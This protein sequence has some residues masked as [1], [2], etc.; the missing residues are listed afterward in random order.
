[1]STAKRD[2]GSTFKE[3]Q[4]VKATERVIKYKYFKDIYNL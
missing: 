3:N 4:K 1:M 2:S